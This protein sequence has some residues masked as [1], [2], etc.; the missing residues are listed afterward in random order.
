MKRIQ[1]ILGNRKKVLKIVLC[2]PTH[3][4]NLVFARPH[5]QKSHI[6]NVTTPPPPDG[7]VRYV[8]CVKLHTCSISGITRGFVL[9]RYTFRLQSLLTPRGQ[10]FP[11]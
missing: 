6:I 5:V 4:Q 2:T 9:R 3:V 11:L 7:M 8:L 10:I 1:Y